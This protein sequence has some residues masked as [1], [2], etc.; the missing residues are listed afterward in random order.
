MTESITRKRQM[1]NRMNQILEAALELFGK[2]GIDYTSVEDVAKQAGVG[3]AT[4]YRYFETKAELAISSAVLYWQRTAGRYVGRLETAAYREASGKEQVAQLMG[5][6]TEIFEKE[7]DFLKFLYEFDTFVMKYQIPQERLAEYEA[8]ILNLKPYV[9]EA[10][11]KGLA[12]G[13]LSF[14]YGVE[15]VYFSLM[16]TLLSL[17]QKLAVN[18]RMLPSDERVALS[19]QVRI[20][21]EIL[22]RGLTSKSQEIS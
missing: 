3:P 19:L 5:L 7:F 18:G 12:D 9:T 4:I 16:H 2:K 15:E 1:Y 6:F 11:T 8:G 20:A 22:L 17:M 13:T 10:L 14:A 21:G